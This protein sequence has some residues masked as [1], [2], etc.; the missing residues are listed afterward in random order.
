MGGLPSPFT[1][2]AFADR[3]AAQTTLL[4]VS[5]DPTRELYQDFNVAFARY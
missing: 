5:Y 1:L 3:T 4:H 2:L